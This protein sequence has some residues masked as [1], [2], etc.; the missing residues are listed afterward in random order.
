MTTLAEFIAAIS[1]WHQLP[2]WKLVELLKEMG[3]IQCT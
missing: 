1:L 2:E 3:V